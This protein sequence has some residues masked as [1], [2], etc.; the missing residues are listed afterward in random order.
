MTRRRAE[1]NW[2]E[3]SRAELSRSSGRIRRDGARRLYPRVFH[4]EREGGRVAL[5]DEIRI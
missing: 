4:R 3:P 2:A 1:L 5:L